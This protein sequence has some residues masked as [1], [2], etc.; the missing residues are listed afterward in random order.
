M[1]PAQL[2]ARRFYLAVGV[3]KAWA[4]AAVDPQC[5]RMHTDAAAC[6]ASCKVDS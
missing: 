4:K 5:Q 1:Q 6:E 3:A 2:E